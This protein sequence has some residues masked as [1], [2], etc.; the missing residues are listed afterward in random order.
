MKHKSTSLRPSWLGRGYH[1]TELFGRLRGQFLLLQRFQR[2]LEALCCGKS[3]LKQV[4]F[5]SFMET[6]KRLMKE[7]G[8]KQRDRMALLP[9]LR[10]EY[11]AGLEGS[12]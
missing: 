11:P 5:V 12:L 10:L 4:P 6:S 2:W 7:E 3:H 1:K 8:I 9:T